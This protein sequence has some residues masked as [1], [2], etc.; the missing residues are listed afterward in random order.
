[1][2]HSFLAATAFAA[3]LFTATPALAAD[4]RAMR[5]NALILKPLILTKISDLDFGTIIRSGRGGG[6][7]V[8]INADTGA[9]TSST[10]ILVSTDPGNQARFASSGLNSQLVFLQLSPPADLING[11]GNR[12]RVDNLR[13]DQANFPLRFLTPASQVF[14]VGIGGQVFVRSN[15]EDGTYTG[16]FNLT[17]YYF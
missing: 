9:R 3:A 12:L 16:T 10:A 2:K 13:L 11:A 8:I 17:A 7:V 4:T 14:F 15:Q 6:D 1:M 5:S